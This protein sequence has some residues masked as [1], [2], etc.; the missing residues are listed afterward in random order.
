MHNVLHASREDVGS[1][2]ALARAHP[3][4]WS[5]AL[6]V[7]QIE[8]PKSPRLLEATLNADEAELNAEIQIFAPLDVAG[9]LSAVMIVSDDESLTDELAEAA[10]LLAARRQVV[11]VPRLGTLVTASEEATQL[12]IDWARRYVAE[13]AS[14]S[15][16]MVVVY[17]QGAEPRRNRSAKHEIPGGYLLRLASAAS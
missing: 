12:L 9:P 11:L 2:C 6:Q 8:S 16:A 10:R 13:H 1:T 5:C 4:R 3:A 17:W 7:A 14:T 15:E